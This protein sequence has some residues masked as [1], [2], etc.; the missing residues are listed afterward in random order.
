MFFA[1][2]INYLDR[3]VLSILAP[4]LQKDLG[5]SELDYGH[6]VFAFQLA[7]AMAMVLAGK[8]ID[9]FGTKIGYAVCVGLWSLASM[10]HAAARSALGFGVARLALGF[11]EAGNFP[12]AIKVIAE[13]FPKK[14]RALANGI[15]NS[16]T[17]VASISAP[18][19]VPWLA[20]TFGW[21]SAFIAIGAVG[22]LWMIVWWLIYEKPEDKKGLD[23]QELAFIQS[24]PADAS[25]E[26]IPW[27][28]LFRYRGVWAY[29][30][31]KLFTDP[32]WWFFLFWLP[33]FLNQKHGLDI[34]A[35]GL[36]LVVIYG[37]CVLGSIW[38]GWLA[39]R[40]IHKG[41]SI[42]ASRKTVMLI[43]ALATVPV[44]FAA[45][46]PS[47]WVV[48]ALISLATAGHCG[49]MANLYS[50]VS[51][52]FPKRAVAS[53]T[54]IGGMAGAL[55]GMFI[56]ELVGWMLETTGQYWPIFVMAACSYVSA[57][58]LICILVPKI[59]TMKIKT[60]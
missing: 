48:V 17:F 32:I 7:Y 24:D 35:M 3:Q 39:S 22:F 60:I 40:L 54:G 41:W 34:Q 43:C 1:T 51:D 11:T 38:A 27:L 47:L 44:G 16:G 13:W 26:K 14:E 28:H 31:G 12:A 50:L 58:I 30:I 20:L 33:K 42:N 57:W 4:T 6:I 59:E 45:K 5:W 52:I 49:W 56:A 46:L 55:G 23:P 9:Q 18:L 8:L 53:V 29:V 19:I 25:A 37:V 21:Q 15:F 2:T 10:G 36:P